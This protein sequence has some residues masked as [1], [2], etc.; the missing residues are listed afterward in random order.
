LPNF[1]AERQS[2]TDYRTPQCRHT[3]APYCAPQLPL[4]VRR[5]ALAQQLIAQ[6]LIS[7]YRLTLSPFL[8]LDCRH[9]PTCSAY[10]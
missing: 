3:G 7:A 9:L 2:S 8:G 10:A 6:A 1:D 4:I 5:C